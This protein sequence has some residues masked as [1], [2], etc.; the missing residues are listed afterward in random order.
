VLQRLS[1]GNCQGEAVWSKANAL[2]DAKRPGDFNQA[3]MELGATICTPRPPQCLVCPLMSWCSTRGADP[4]LRR[5]VRKHR[6][7][8]Y[9]LARRNGAVMLVRRPRD[10]KLMAGMWEL[11]ISVVEQ[12]GH[13]PLAKFRH[14]I[15]DTDYEV[16]V[17]ERRD[18]C[19]RSDRKGSFD[20]G[21]QQTRASA[22][23][24]SK[25]GSLRQ[26]SSGAAQADAVAAR[27]CTRQQWQRMALTGLTRKILRKLEG[28]S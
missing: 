17:H 20:C 8:S 9:V 1:G 23:D 26:A 22:Q 11:P 19:E 10:A 2:L 12:N 27:W 7:V 24:D 15:T 18:D 21:A 16:V 6:Q 28:E 4:K 13:A 5:A 14:S 3:M 25:K